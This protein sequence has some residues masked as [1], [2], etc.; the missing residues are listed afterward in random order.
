MWF[1][2]ERAWRSLGELKSR[3]EKGL[4]V[5]PVDFAPQHLHAVEEDLIQIERNI[6]TARE[7]FPQR[8]SELANQFQQ[9]ADS[10]VALKKQILAGEP[11]A[12]QISSAEALPQMQQQWTEF[13]SSQKRQRLNDE[14][15]KVSPDVRRQWNLLHDI[16]YQLPQLLRWHQLS[17]RT[18]ATD[19]RPI[20]DLLESSLTIEDQF[21]S[22]QASTDL[23]SGLAAGEASRQQ[24]ERAA[25]HLMRA[26]EDQVKSLSVDLDRKDA[27]DSLSRSRMIQDTLATS[28]VPIETRVLLLKR[29]RS[30]AT[31]ETSL[32]AVS[33]SDLHQQRLS[34]VLQSDPS[35]RRAQDHAE[36]Y[37]AFESNLRQHLSA[38]SAEVPA[39]APLSQLLL[40]CSSCSEEARYQLALLTP[41][42]GGQLLVSRCFASVRFPERPVEERLDLAAVG[43]TVQGVSTDW[44]TIEVRLT[45]RGAQPVDV[46]FNVEYDREALQVH[47]LRVET[48]Q[49]GGVSLDPE[50]SQSVTLAATADHVLRFQVRATGLAKDRLTAKLKLAAR[51]PFH[52]RSLTFD[53]GLPT[54]N[55]VV[56]ITRSVHLPPGFIGEDI[57]FYPNRDNEIQCLLKNE[58]GHE[59]EFRVDLIESPLPFKRGMTTEELDQ[60]HRTVMSRGSNLRTDLKIL[61]TAPSVKIGPLQNMD[62]KLLDPQSFQPPA[63]PDAPPAPPAPPAEPA[64]PVQLKY[65]LLLVLREIGTP[66][67]DS[68]PIVTVQPLIT[69][70]LHPRQYL[71]ARAEYDPAARRVTAYVSP[72]QNPQTG[73]PDLQAVPHDWGTTPLKVRMS[74][75]RNLPEGT[76]R[77][78]EDDLS[79]EN[80]QATVFVAGL[81]EGQEYRFALDVDGYPRAFVFKGIAGQTVV[82]PVTDLQE[83][84]ISAITAQGTPWRFEP[85]ASRTL[86]IPANPESELKPREVIRPAFLAPLAPDSRLVVHLQADA[87]QDAFIGTDH[88]DRISLELSRLSNNHVEF[89]SDRQEQLTFL[90]V[91]P[92]SGDVRVRCDVA[93]L[94]QEF[95]L[96][97]DKDIELTISAA[98]VLGTSEFPAQSIKVALD[99]RPPEVK[100]VFLKP[101]RLKYALEENLSVVIQAEDLSAV[102]T[103]SV[104]IRHA[105]SGQSLTPEPLHAVRTGHDSWQVEISP[106]GHKLQAGQRYQ[107]FATLTDQVGNKIESKPVS[108]EIAVPA[109]PAMA[110]MKEETP[111]PEAP[112]KGVIKGR[113]VKSG[114]PQPRSQI[115]VDLVGAGKGQLTVDANGEFLFTEVS[116]GSYTL[117]AT[118]NLR[119][120]SH[121]GELTGVSPSPT[122]DPITVDLE[123]KIGN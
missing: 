17:S 37:R 36:L 21:R 120:V 57:R 81:E 47:R 75:L 63:S 121:S 44:K 104:L 1:Q 5:T 27:L 114:R 94:K 68:S 108:L 96:L 13:C 15:S 16:Q 84:A 14:F 52:S 101:N 28:L 111:A 119:G 93:D 4:N 49:G 24:F 58:S 98:M 38:V 72:K 8:M 82:R 59:R 106:A 62:V 25:Q 50:N 33:G 90:G 45:R 110:T 83:I 86:A 6:W 53:F 87:P 102:E 100:S 115:K 41:N 118:G 32:M 7:L 26:F 117:K 99:G 91:H 77:S 60:L 31:D 69:A 79:L 89:E 3:G 51:N 20:R 35:R 2:L 46:H 105:I 19:S 40:S 56:L 61:A 29:I 123:V 55:R 71:E 22:L 64:E 88:A 76:P 18:R 10:L 48:L 23:K 65:G 85:Q 116:P 70:H 122:D 113:I 78:V 30:E 73:R 74:Q 9:F 103:V 11:L 107:I 95:N 80:G 112:K 67:S 39:E 12:W 109:P 34:E 66:P 54:P 92:E 43:A 97:A 42:P